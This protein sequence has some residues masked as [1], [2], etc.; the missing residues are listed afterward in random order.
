MDVKFHFRGVKISLCICMNEH[1][2][3]Y[4]IQENGH[5]QDWKFEHRR[6]G[7]DDFLR[8]LPLE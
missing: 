7:M 1:D 2:E 6:L 5:V 8:E 4:D 3:D